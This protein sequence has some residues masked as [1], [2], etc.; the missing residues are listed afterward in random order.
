MRKVFV[1]VTA[2]LTV[3]TALQIYFAA[4]GVFSV[5]DDHLFAIHGTNGRI[6]LPILVLLTILTAAL[7]R[8]GKRT[9]WL[10]VIVFGLLI[11]Q[12]LFFILTGVIFGVTE[13]STEVP[14]AATLF[15]SLHGL[16]GLAIIALSATLF[17]RARRL[18]REPR[19]SARKADA[20]PSPAE[21]NTVPRA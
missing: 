1:V 15:V 6:V 2:L 14:L 12:T 8:A 17:A 20:T 18:A 19:D 10:S 11:L 21:V 16:N 4:M 3:S 9:I 7:A 13:E 5:P